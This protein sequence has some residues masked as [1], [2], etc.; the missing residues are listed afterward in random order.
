[1]GDNATQADQK[2][3]SQVHFDKDKTYR[4]MKKSPWLR[5]ISS[6]QNVKGE[7]RV[8]LPVETQS[9]VATLK[10]Q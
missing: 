9:K 8:R 3:K 4:P 7:Q 1:V 6:A 2:Q 10:F 5:R